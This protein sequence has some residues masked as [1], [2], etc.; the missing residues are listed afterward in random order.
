MTA[1]EAKREE[2]TDEELVVLRKSFG[3]VPRSRLENATPLR[4][5]G[6]EHFRRI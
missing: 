4:A 6:N 3:L 5:S 1:G 2:A